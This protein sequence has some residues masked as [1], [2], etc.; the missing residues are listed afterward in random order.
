MVLKFDLFK[1]HVPEEDINIRSWI[2]VRGIKLS[3]LLGEMI[4]KVME[5]GNSLNKISSILSK[6]LD[7]PIG[8]VYSQLHNF[9]DSSLLL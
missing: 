4:S 5:K 9:S 1:L 3:I 6:D 8:T 7:I 2:R